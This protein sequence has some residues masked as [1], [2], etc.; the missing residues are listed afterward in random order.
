MRGKQIAEFQGQ[1]TKK[2]TAY[3]VRKAD[4]AS[5]DVV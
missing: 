3:V 2:L 1:R 5:E 4:S